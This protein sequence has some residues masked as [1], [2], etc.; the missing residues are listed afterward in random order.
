MPDP[1]D[2]DVAAMQDTRALG[3]TTM[4]DPKDLDLEVMP[5]SRDLDLAAMVWIHAWVWHK[6]NSFAHTGIF[7]FSRCFFYI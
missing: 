6:K 2:M 7:V 3:M 1:N 5:H 4:L